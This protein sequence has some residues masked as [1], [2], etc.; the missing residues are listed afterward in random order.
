M[1]PVTKEITEVDILAEVIAPSE[2]GMSPEAA[3]SILEFKFRPKTLERINELT[4]KNRKDTLSEAERAELQKYLRVGNFL[5]LVQAKAR[6]SL[7]AKSPS[8]G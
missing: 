6:V 1:E 3:R 4:E 5:S 2:P 7:L 8:H